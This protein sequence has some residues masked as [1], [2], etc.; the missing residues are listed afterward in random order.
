MP[1]RAR[2]PGTRHH[3]TER[4]SS[5]LSS[6]TARPSLSR[7]PAPS[8]PCPGHRAR[9]S[10][11]RPTCAPSGTAEAPHGAAI[12][13]L[14]ARARASRV[15]SPL[16]TRT[17]LSPQRTLRPSLSHG[18][19]PFLY[20]RYPTMCHHKLPRINSLLS[21]TQSSPLTEQRGGLCEAH[22]IYCMHASG[23]ISSQPR[24]SLS[25]SSGVL[26]GGW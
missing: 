4:T 13:A 25:F 5:L 10:G 11:L 2:Y 3:R 8:A 17:L 24:S 15:H 26:A 1:H 7:P 12:H 14:R 6:H 9:S 19:L 20:A 22:I 23:G 16:G 21:R 18:A